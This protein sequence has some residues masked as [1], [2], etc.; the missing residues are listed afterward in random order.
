LLLFLG[1][2]DENHFPFDI[3]FTIPISAG[4]LRRRGTGGRFAN[5][6]R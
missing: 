4:G 1:E 5:R 2:Q 6:H 3:I